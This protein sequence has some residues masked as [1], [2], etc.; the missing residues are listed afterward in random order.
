MLRLIVAAPAAA[1][2]PLPPIRTDVPK[3]RRRMRTAALPRRLFPATSVTR[4]T[5]GSARA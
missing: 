4:D 1:V 3:T 2:P 5:V